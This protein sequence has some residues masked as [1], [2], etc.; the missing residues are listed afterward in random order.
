MRWIYHLKRTQEPIGD[1][2]YAPVRFP[3]EGFVHCS[4][5][6]K[7]K[8]S[9]SIYFSDG[10]SLE[11]FRIDPVRLDVRVEIART[12]RGPMPHVMGT[13]PHDAIR[14]REPLEKAQLIDR[15]PEPQVV[16]A[17]REDP[18]GSILDGAQVRTLSMEEAVKTDLEAFDLVVVLAAEL[19]EAAGGAALDERLAGLPQ[20]RVLRAEGSLLDVQSRLRMG[21]GEA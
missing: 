15:R 5:A 9:A 10:D 17:T 11:V 1:T 20:N 6:H 7:V 8:E 3:E 12:P 19:K 2:R 4:F 18:V 21:S 16:I 14:A 13:I